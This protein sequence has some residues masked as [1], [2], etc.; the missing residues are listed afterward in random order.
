MPSKTYRK[1]CGFLSS[2][3][4]TELARIFSNLIDLVNYIIVLY[5]L[6]RLLYSEVI[7]SNLTV[8]WTISVQL[9]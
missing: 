4:E 8:T 3:K 2:L 1:S 6:E 5:G 7:G 9:K